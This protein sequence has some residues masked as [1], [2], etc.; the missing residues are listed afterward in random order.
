MII[1]MLFIK[2]Y[3]L[4]KKTN[5]DSENTMETHCYVFNASYYMDGDFRSMLVAECRIVELSFF[6]FSFSFFSFFSFLFFFFF[7]FYQCL[8]GAEVVV[9]Q[10]SN[11]HSESELGIY[12][13]HLSQKTKETNTTNTRQTQNKKETQTNEQSLYQN[14][15]I[16]QTK[17]IKTKQKSRKITS[18]T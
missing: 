14:K 7:F 3:I 1:L 18:V 5:Q 17:Q 13:I 10:Y 12:Y 16:Q 9:Q 4:Q 2:Q 6:F 11:I 15:Q 8:I